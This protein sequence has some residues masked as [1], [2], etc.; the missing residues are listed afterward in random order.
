MFP[1]IN[2]SAVLWPDEKNKT[3]SALLQSKKPELLQKVNSEMGGY[4]KNDRLLIKT[5]ENDVAAAKKRLA[6]LLNSLA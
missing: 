1:A 2:L 5:A 4:V 6:L 3:I